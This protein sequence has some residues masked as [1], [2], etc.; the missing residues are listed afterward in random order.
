M[1]LTYYKG[2][3]WMAPVRICWPACHSLCCVAE[4]RSTSS[5]VDELLS[6]LLETAHIS[7]HLILC[8]DS[9]PC[10]GCNITMWVQSLSIFSQDFQYTPRLKLVPHSH[11]FIF[12]SVVFWNN[13]VPF[14]VA[15]IRQ[16]Q[17]F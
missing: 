17:E 7:F 15:Y 14:Y 4:V 11:F 13:S 8:V 3:E 16:N 12:Y 6:K 2:R 9:K 1:M 10:Q 5:V